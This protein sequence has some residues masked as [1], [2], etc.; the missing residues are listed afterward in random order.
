M[1]ILKALFGSYSKRELKRIDPI[2]K[3]VLALADKYRAM[4]E[5]ELKKTTPLLKE[6]LANGETL[7]DILPDAFA[8]CREASDRVLGMR[9]FPV[10][11]VGG[12][13]L[14]QGRIS[15][16]KTGEGKTLSLI[17]I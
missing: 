10:Q 16:M 5:E 4:S 1:N 12:I 2:C 11:I 17:H 6:R 14:H 13:V 7:D 9:H 3:K 8:A 15:E